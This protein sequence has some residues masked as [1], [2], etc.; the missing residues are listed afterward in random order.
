MVYIGKFAQQEGWRS[1]RDILAFV[2]ELGCKAL[3]KRMRIN[4][5][6]WESSGE[7]GRSQ[8]EICNTILACRTREEA[9]DVVRDMEEAMAEDIVVQLA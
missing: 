2:E 6:C 9:E 5:K 1:W 3:A 7:F 4:N 8:V